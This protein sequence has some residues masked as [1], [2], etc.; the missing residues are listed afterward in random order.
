MLLKNRLHVVALLLLL[1]AC[2]HA[3][4]DARP[5]GQV[6]EKALVVHVIDVGQGDGILIQTPDGKN[7]LLDTGPRG[8]TRK[9]V[10]PYLEALGVTRL[11]GIIISHSHS[12]HAGGLEF[13]AG[14]FDVGALY[15]SGFF[16]ESGRNL[17]ALKKFKKAGIPHKTVRQGAVLKL[18]A[19]VIV[20][21]L[22]PPDFWEGRASQVNDFS[23]FMRL[24]YGDMDFM[25]TGDGEVPAERSVLGSKLALKSEFL[26]VGHHGSESSSSPEFLDA[27]APDYG[28]ISCGRKKQFGHPHEPVLKRLNERKVKLYRTDTQGTIIVRTDGYDVDIKTL[29]VQ[30]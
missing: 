13:F 18:G 19:D 15:S 10:F 1:S 5:D 29:G 2:A 30:E 9:I 26:K 21:I 23:I 11:D 20:K 7:Y 22:H 16:H 6:G 28:I 25:F 17:R 8:P 24:S 4:P 12:D 14:K 27:V 3:S